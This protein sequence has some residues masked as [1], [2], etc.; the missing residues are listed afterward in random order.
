MNCVACNKE[1]ASFKKYCNKLCQRAYEAEKIEVTCRGCGR[2]YQVGRGYST[3]K[4]FKDQCLECS[5]KEGLNHL[6]G[7]ESPTW[8]GG[9]RYWSPGRFGRD[10]DRL[11]WKA[12]RQLA[13]ERDNYE[14]QHC[15][16]KKQRKPDVH[17]IIPWRISQSHALNN[18]ISLCQSCH[19]K[20]EAK[21][22]EVSTEIGYRPSLEN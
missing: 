14:C 12:Q 17:H 13:W 18:L 15:H 22:K 20:E 3:K 2:E 4:A 7:P 8:K 10:K 16:K 5:S 21:N 19:L 11:S 6:P 1:I 9:Y